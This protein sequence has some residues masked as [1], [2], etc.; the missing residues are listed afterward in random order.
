MVK[1]LYIHLLNQLLYQNWTK[2]RRIVPQ[3]EECVTFTLE[4]RFSS[5]LVA[6]L[7]R[8]MIFWKTN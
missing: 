5:K 1:N 2:K 3:N 6:V 4:N 7:F 8:D